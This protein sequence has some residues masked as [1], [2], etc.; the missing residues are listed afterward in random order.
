MHHRQILSVKLTFFTKTTCSLCVN[1]KNVL[2]STILEDPIKLLNPQLSVID[3]SDPKNKKWFDAY[4]FDV[5]VLHVERPGL[6]LVKF[7]HYFYKDKLTAELTRK[8]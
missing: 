6:P 2:Q 8:H 1:A 7:M 5:P 4:C 3:I